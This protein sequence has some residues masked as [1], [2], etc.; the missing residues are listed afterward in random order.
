MGGIARGLE[1]TTIN[2][3][4]ASL[5][6]MFAGLHELEVLYSSTYIILRYNLLYMYIIPVI[7]LYREL[8]N[9]GGRIRR[10]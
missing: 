2:H 5:S 7:S 3:G 1:I 6:G 8:Y 4:I 10:F 9:Y